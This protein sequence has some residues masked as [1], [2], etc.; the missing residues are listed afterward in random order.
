MSTQIN[1]VTL[2]P[3]NDGLVRAY[4]NIVFDNCFMSQ[5][6]RVSEL[7]G[8]IVRVQMP[9]VKD[10]PTELIMNISIDGAVHSF[11]FILKK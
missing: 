7:R 8:E 4:V 3:S 1:E 9:T 5:E 10:S 6:I 11:R 2:Y